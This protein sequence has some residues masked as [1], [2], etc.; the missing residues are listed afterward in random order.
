VSVVLVVWIVEELVEKTADLLIVV[1]AGT[2]AAVDG[3][4]AGE[5]AEIVPVPW[6]QPAS[7][8]KKANRALTPAVNLFFNIS[9]SYPL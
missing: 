4:V 8:K 9:I 1:E 7:R 3:A 5:V 2:V 6:L